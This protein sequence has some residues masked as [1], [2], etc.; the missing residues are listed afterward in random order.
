[1]YVDA[2][3]WRMGDSLLNFGSLFGSSITEAR[4]LSSNYIDKEAYRKL[5]GVGSTNPAD[6]VAD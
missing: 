4:F 6:L 1:M 5:Q 3:Y 2:L